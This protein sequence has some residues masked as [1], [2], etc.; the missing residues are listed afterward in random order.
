MPAHNSNSSWP[1]LTNSLRTQGKS[2]SKKHWQI[3]KHKKWGGGKAR[4]GKNSERGPSSVGN[5]RWI[6]A[7]G[8][9]RATTKSKQSIAKQTVEKQKP[10][11][12]ITNHTINIYTIYNELY[13]RLHVCRYAQVQHTFTLF[14]PFVA[15][16]EDRCEHVA[17]SS[18]VGSQAYYIVIPHIIA[19]TQLNSGTV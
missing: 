5:M 2:L 17:I 19:I 1:R 12:G 6:V 10:N 4:H 13:V 14:V 11:S 8:G 18:D 15:G 3:R 9:E 16:C 7:I